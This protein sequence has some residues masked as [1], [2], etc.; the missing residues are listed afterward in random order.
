MQIKINIKNNKE[1]IH[2]LAFIKALLIKESI[3][4]LV[5]EEFYAE[6]RQHRSRRRSCRMPQKRDVQSQTVERTHC[7]VYN[8]R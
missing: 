6:G 2:N 3:E 8:F 4:K 1:Y 7:F 5:G